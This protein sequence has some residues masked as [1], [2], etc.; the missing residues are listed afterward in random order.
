MKKLNIINI[1]QN[2]LPPTKR[3]TIIVSFLKVLTT[4][5]QSLNDYLVNTYYPDVTRRTRWNSQ[6]LLFSKLLNDLHNP[7]LRNITIDGGA[8]DL[9]QEYVYN[10]IEEAPEY[11]YNVSESQPFYLH[12][13]SEYVSDIDFV[14]NY[15]SSIEDKKN[16]IEAT[17]KKYKIAGSNYMLQSF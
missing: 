3:Q 12:N 4:P 10:E 11:F 5:L 15:P 8:S 17:V 1:I 13:I 2:L 14:V 9:E 6:V 7:D 16:Q